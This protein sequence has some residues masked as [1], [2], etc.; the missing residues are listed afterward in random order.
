MYEMKSGTCSLLFVCI[1]SRVLLYLYLFFFLVTTV[2]NPSLSISLFVLSIL[3]KIYLD[4]G[5]K[6]V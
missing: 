5:L 2:V 3:T 1:V 6:R 4:V